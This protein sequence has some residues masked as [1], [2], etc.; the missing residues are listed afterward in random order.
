MAIGY[1]IDKARVDRYMPAV[2]ALLGQLCLV[3]APVVQDETEATDLRCCT[4]SD[5][6]FAVRIRV[7]H[8]KHFFSRQCPKHRL[9]NPATDLRAP[10]ISPHKPKAQTVADCA[11]LRAAVSDPRDRLILEL[12]YRAGLR[13]FEVPLI[14][15]GQVDIGGGVLQR[16][17]RKGSKY[18]DVALSP[19]VVA[20]IEKYQYTRAEKLGPYSTVSDYPLVLSSH[21]TLLSDPESFRLSPES[22]YRTIKR[23]ALAAGID[24][25]HPH[26]L[27]HS[28]V[29]EFLD[30][31]GDIRLTAQ[32]AGHSNINTTMRY[33][34]ATDDAI[35]NAVRKLK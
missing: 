17:Q 23:I 29:S 1:E 22:V 3:D 15:W 5:L 19:S 16:L 35:R 33:A 25:A 32:A 24:G 18:Q 20:A 10:T 13:R 4:M 8:A 27:R 21:L 26:R 34:V 11:S 30:L 6:R 28:F 31:T 2:R 14:N 12:L 7:A 9:T